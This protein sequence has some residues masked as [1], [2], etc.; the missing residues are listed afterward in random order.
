M[1]F[2]E[3]AWIADRITS[4]HHDP[5]TLE[6]SKQAL[7][8]SK[9]A[10]PA[11]LLGA[12]ALLPWLRRYLGPSSQEKNINGTLLLIILAIALC[13]RLWQCPVA[14]DDSYVDYR[15]VL[16]WLSGHFD[17]NDGEHVMGFTSHLHLL[18]LW[19]LCSI[20]QTHTVDLTS[21][22]LNCAVDTSNCLLLF[23]LIYQLF[24]GK[25]PAFAAALIYA[26]N[27]Y[28]CQE[29]VSGKETALVT[30]TAL[31]AMLAIENKR[32]GILPWCANALFLLRPEGLLS[33]LVVLLTAFKNQTR[34]SFIRSALLPCLITAALY[35]FLFSYFGTIMPHGMVAKAKIWMPMALAPTIMIPLYTIS[36]Q[37]VNASLSVFLHGN[38]DINYAAGTIAI[39]LFML[40]R[41][42]EPGLALYRNIALVQL[43]FLLATRPAYFGWYF[44]WFT[45][46]GPLLLAKLTTLNCPKALWQRLWKTTLAVQIGL[47]AIIGLYFAPYNWLWT[48]QRVV[49]YREAAL[50]LLAKTG[51]KEP[52]CASDVGMI[53]Y[54]YPGPIVD[55]QGLVTDESLRYYPIKK[56]FGLWNFAKY[57]I[58]PEAVSAMKP[59][60]LVAAATIC[61]GLLLEDADFKKH[62][63]ILK[64][65][66]DE[67]MVGKV[68]YIFERQPKPPQAMEKQ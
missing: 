32:F 25:L 58:P 6:R 1:C 49:V 19:L 51:G 34:S 50:Y 59:K 54:T 36:S 52:I 37:A 30:M 12:L 67:H 43:G 53:G 14:G 48:L 45:L 64:Q 15:Y 17:Y 62:Y 63:S 55:I 2:L 42:K 9:I 60:Y 21:Y 61:D 13:L 41:Y 28:C 33:C 3:P 16:R 47:S 38:N 39:F 57:L 18:I 24:K 31:I 46:L 10:I 22:Y 40:W 35:L 66:N 27:V 11:T 23:T 4:L 65:W 68:V 20:F 5:F 26:T 56:D 7:Q 8:V 44:C 29:V